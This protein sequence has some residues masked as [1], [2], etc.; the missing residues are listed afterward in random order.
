MVKGVALRTSNLD[1]SDMGDASN[2]RRITSNH[3]LQRPRADSNASRHMGR[4]SSSTLSSNSLSKQ[5]DLLS[6]SSLTSLPKGVGSLSS[7]APA[8]VTNATWDIPPPPESLNMFDLEMNEVIPSS[9]PSTDATYKAERR[10]TWTP[11]LLPVQQSLLVDLDDELDSEDEP[12]TPLKRMSER[13]F[14]DVFVVDTFQEKIPKQLDVH[15]LTPDDLATLKESDPFMYYSI[16][17]VKQARREG[18]DVDFDITLSK[19]VKRSSAISFESGDIP[20]LGEGFYDAYV[21]DA[22][23]HQED[24]FLS[25]FEGFDRQ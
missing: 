19:P 22:G 21:G 15:R 13:S 3:Q 8:T 2:M 16:P 1:P 7:S 9:S 20:S 6:S 24:L 11:A 12:E 18:K 14:D 23:E 10:N 5:L 17:A 25:V 4:R